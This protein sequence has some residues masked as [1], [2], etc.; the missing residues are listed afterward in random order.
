MLELHIIDQSAYV[1]LIFQRMLEP[2]VFFFGAN[3]GRPSLPH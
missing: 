2:S 3:Q 1:V